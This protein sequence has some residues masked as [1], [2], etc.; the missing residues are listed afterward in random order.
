LRGEILISD[1]TGKI[2]QSQKT[3]G[4]DINI[5]L[6]VSMFHSGVYLVQLMAEG[7]TIATKKLVME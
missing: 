5:G 6:D 4:G 3:I 1:I 7:K 2:I